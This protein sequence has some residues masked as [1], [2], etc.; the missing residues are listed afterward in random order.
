[1]YVCLCAGVTEK[2]IEQHF[3][4]GVDSLDALASRT[5]C[6]TVCGCCREFAAQ[7]LDALGSVPSLPVLRLAAA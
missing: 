2:D 7:K 4:D 5:G 3:E 6:G 1:M